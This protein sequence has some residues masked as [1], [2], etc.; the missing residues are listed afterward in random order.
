MRKID[1]LASRILTNL[2]MRQYTSINLKPYPCCRG[3]HS[4]LDAMLELVRKENISPQDV[5]SIEVRVV[6]L[7]STTLIH[8]NPQTGDEG[9]FS[10][11]FCM[12]IAI[13]N[14]QVGVRE[15]TDKIVLDATTQNLIRKVKMIPDPELDKAKKK[16]KPGASP[17]IVTVRLKNGKEYTKRV[18]FAKGHPDIPLSREELLTKYKDCA[19]SVL[20]KE[21]VDRSI[22]MIENM[23]GIKNLR[24]L[25]DVLI[26]GR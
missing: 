12:A 22:D 20:S 5:E 24:A 17:A 1:P 10:M 9:K 11:K 19:Q 3:A 6:P 18:D 2:F 21:A 4:S 15:F 16:L 23:E 14:R 26:A 7:H 13:L 8:S 25:A